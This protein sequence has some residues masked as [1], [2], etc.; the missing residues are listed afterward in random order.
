[1]A[2]FRPLLIASAC[3]LYFAIPLA[4]Q[5]GSAAIRPADGGAYFQTLVNEAK[6]RIREIGADQLVTLQ[7]ATPSP[8]LVVVREDNEWDKVRIPGAIHVGRGVLEVKIESRI[9]QKTTPI[10][11]YCQGGGRAAVAADVLAKMGYTNV[12]WLA[13]GLAAYQAAGLPLDKS[14]SPK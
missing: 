10:V 8:V 13:G 11:V 6:T 4:A 2:R 14:A 5:V 7:K 1:M 9:P 3:Y 12:V